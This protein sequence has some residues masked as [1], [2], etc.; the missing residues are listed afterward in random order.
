MSAAVRAVALVVAAV[1]FAGA[2]DAAAELQ[3][4]LR[5]QGTPVDLTA[6]TAEQRDVVGAL[7][8]TTLRRLGLSET[9]TTT[10]GDR[11]QVYWYVGEVDDVMC[12]ARGI[13]PL[14]K[15]EFERDTFSAVACR[16][17]RR[18][19]FAATTFPSRRQPLLLPLSFIRRRGDA[20]AR[21]PILCGLA[22]DDVARV[23]IVSARGQ[24]RLT[25][26]R[27]NFACVDRIGGLRLANVHAAAI[28]AVDGRGRTL[29]RRRLHRFLRARA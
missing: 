13:V 6:L 15:G 4:P 17:R 26:V 14:M 9:L 20:Y 21:I 29:Y 12:F 18:R 22:A 2:G 24:R 25:T 7:G 11:F 1:V 19:P 5:N 10:F 23:G 8:F 3:L 16:G 27:D 28:V